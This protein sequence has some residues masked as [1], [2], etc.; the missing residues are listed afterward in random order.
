MSL[1]EKE[2]QVD[3]VEDANHNDP[4]AGS[5]STDQSKEGI[6]TVEIDEG[7]YIEVDDAQISSDLVTLE[8]ELVASKKKPFLASHWLKSPQ[9]FVW[10]LAILAS[11]GGFLFGIDQSLISGASLYI[12]DDIAL[13]TSELSMVVGFTP[14]GAMLGA[15]CLMPINDTFGRKGAIIIST[16]IFTVG[17]IMEAA[18][19]GYAVL[20]TGRII[21]GVA[22]G[23]LSGTIPAYISENCPVKWRGGLVSLYQVMVGFGVM[24]G[25]V[26]AAIFNSVKG[27]WRYI[28]GSSIVFSTILF[29]GM[30]TLPESTRWLMKRGRKRDAY[31]VWKYVRGFD[32]D[33]RLEFY[34]MEQV[35]LYE[36]ERTKGRWVFL[37]LFFRPRCLR[38]VT[39]AVVLALIC[40]QMSGINSIEYYQAS[41]VEQA[42]LTAQDA[43]YS[44]LV[45]GGAMFFSTLPAIILMDRWGR[46]T[47]ILST[48]PGAVIGLFITGF[49]FLGNTLG[50]RLGLYFWGMVTYTCFWA[51]GLGAG[52]WAFASEIYPT[53]LRSYGMSL[54]ALCNW[55]GTFIT[56]Y[57][58]AKMA[59]AMTKTG[60]FA[61]LY[62]GLLIVGAIYLMLFMPE[63]KGLTLEE[64]N[65]VFERPMSETMHINIRNL[66]VTFDDLLHFRLRKIFALS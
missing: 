29:C 2:D 11:A 15:L 61:G 3:H 4:E 25:Y 1:S 38:A 60:V 50:V 66:K 44:S 54:A 41:L 31:Q 19:M 5:K 27:N 53:Y 49:S 23:L 28:L 42:G 43:V 8:A 24:C 55:T 14:L 65:T 6:R 57:P 56:T 32:Q 63:T 52:P 48:I 62:A 18:A 9:A 47:L 37:D 22:L 7:K 59:A 13:T 21:L 36:K 20:L 45:G 30:I 35:V 58:F 64:I 26:V 40:Q 34:V 12:T 17:A 16:V 10:Y 46:R 39:T 33:E 51:P